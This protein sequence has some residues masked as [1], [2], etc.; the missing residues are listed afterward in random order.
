MP[1]AINPS[2][3]KSE[4][5]S[6]CV[7]EEIGYGKT[8]EQSVAICNSYWRSNKNLSSEERFLNRINLYPTKEE[9]KEP[10]YKGYEQYGMK[11][12]NGVKVP[13]CIKIDS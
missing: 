8:P 1:I 2:E 9:L 12:K 10:C 5:I 7:S 4:F 3:E 6:R 13:N 11:I